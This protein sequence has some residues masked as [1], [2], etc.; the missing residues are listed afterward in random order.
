M[1]VAV[2]V[3][4]APLPVRGQEV[5]GVDSSC[6]PAHAGC[7]RGLLTATARG[8]GALGLAVTGLDPWID[9]GH[10]VTACGVTGGGL[11]TAS[12]HI[13]SV[14]VFSLPAGDIGVTTSSR[15]LSG[16]ARVTARGQ[17]GDY[18]APARLR[19]EEP[20]VKPRRVLRSLPLSLLWF[21]KRRRLFLLLQEGRFSPRFRLIC[22]VLPGVFEPVRI[23]FPVA[24]G[25][26]AGMTASAAGS[27]GAVCPS[28]AAGGAV[29]FFVYVCAGC[30]VWVLL[31]P[32]TSA[33]GAVTVGAATGDACWR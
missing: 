27:G 4:L 21:L 26:I 9:T 10:T 13:I 33:A 6:R 18:L 16:I 28:T 7:G 20:D 32:S 29:I 24:I 25:G 8:V 11:L 31:C 2:V 3:A 5:V 22:R 23:L 1:V 19:A 14:C 12:S 17:A 30:W 15:T